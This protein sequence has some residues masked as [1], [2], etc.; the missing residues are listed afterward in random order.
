MRRDGHRQFIAGEQHAGALFFGQRQVFFE[1][2]E[3]RDPV[4]ELPGGAVPVGGGDVFGVP[5]AWSQGAELLLRQRVGVVHVLRDR[6]A[7]RLGAVVL[8]CQTSPAFVWVHS[9]HATCGSPDT[10]GLAAIS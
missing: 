6:W 1:L 4:L 9:L 5:K 3:G 7:R 10:P 2:S 8:E